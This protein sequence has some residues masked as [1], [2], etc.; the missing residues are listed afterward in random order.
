M[1]KLSKELVVQLWDY[2][3]GQ[4]LGRDC[5]D[6]DSRKKQFVEEFIKWTDRLNLI[7]PVN[8]KWLLSYLIWQ[9][10][11][12]QSDIQR[13]GRSWRG[14]GI[15]T[16]KL[17]WLLSKE[18]RKRYLSFLNNPKYTFLFEGTKNTFLTFYDVKSH[19]YSDFEDKTKLNQYEEKEKERFFNTEAGLL[20]CIEQTTLFNSNSKYCE[21]CNF[22]TSCKEI[23]RQRLTKINRQRNGINFK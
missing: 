22:K 5:F 10:E 15:A 20:W 16:I 1:S 12:Y 2:L 21:S 13:K 17:H 18:A 7:V 6:K 14:K 8:F 4:M 9:I 11:F 19:F 3:R 23:L